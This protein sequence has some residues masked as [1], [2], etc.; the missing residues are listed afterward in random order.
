MYIKGELL[1]VFTNFRLQCP[2]QMSSQFTE[3]STDHQK[4]E[5]VDHSAALG[6]SPGTIIQDKLK[7][8]LI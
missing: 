3:N 1:I 2:L 7:N 8:M 5:P 4:G 6:Y